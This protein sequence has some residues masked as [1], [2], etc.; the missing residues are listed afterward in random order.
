MLHVRIRAGGAEPSA[1]LPRPSQTGLRRR[2]EN[3]VSSH[4]ETKATAP[5]P[6]FT[7]NSRGGEEKATLVLSLI[8][9]RSAEST[10]C[11]RLN[12]NTVS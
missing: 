3:I 6:D 1:S 2:R 12:L 7:R 5:V 4:P 9:N 10:N 11:P 8:R